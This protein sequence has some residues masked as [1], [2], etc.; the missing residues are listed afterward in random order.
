[1]ARSFVIGAAELP[2][3]DK[4]V[5][6]LAILWEELG[7]AASRARENVG[8]E[9]LVLLSAAKIP[10]VRRREFIKRFQELIL[11]FGSEDDPTGEPY[12]LAGALFSA[13]ASDAGGN[14]AS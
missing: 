10:Q 14:P 12:T 6:A 8:G 9:Q 1:M 11:A 7:L 4:A 13:A 2:Q 3:S 5:V